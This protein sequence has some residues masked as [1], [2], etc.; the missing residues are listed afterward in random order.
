MDDHR[1]TDAL[2]RYA[3]PG[4]PP[5]GG[6]ETLAA[7]VGAARRRRRTLGVAGVVAAV[8]V[9]V[10]AASWLRPG[11]PAVVDPVTDPETGVVRGGDWRPVADGPLSPRYDAV[12]TW[13]GD[14]LV[15]V[16]GTSGFVCPPGADCEPPEQDTFHAD[17]AAYDPA[18]D[19]WRRLPDAPRPLAGGLAAWSGS[20]V[21]VVSGRAT[22]ALD[23]AGG[24]WRELEASPGSFDRVVATDAGLAFSSYDQGSRTAVSDWLLDP[25]SGRWNPLPHDPFGESYDRSLAWDGE[26]LWLLSM[27]VDEHGGAHE[28]SP[29]RL[30]V[31]EGGLADGTW[32]VVEDATPDLTYEQDAWWVD[33]RLVIPPSSYNAGVGRTYAPAA[34]AWTELEP[35]DRDDEKCP[36]PAAGVGP[37]WVSGGGPTLV[38]A[39][40]SGTLTVPR[41]EQL[42]EADVAVWA[43]E[44]LLVWGGIGPGW[45]E[46]VAV[47]L[48]WAPPYSSGNS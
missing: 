7:R 41:C 15:V 27:S 24:T 22:L 39:D 17:A 10:V 13:T 16:G 8:A 34:G 47:G 19:T 36:L 32:R 29:S 28:G 38:S 23:P 43:G 33:G 12:G 3:A 44:T 37:E 11:D 45:E 4:T 18:T 5:P 6:R 2:R 1:L 26:R 35:L 21:V 40:G 20:E 9:I 48:A 42:A 25:D 31:L 30:A 46:P 14:E